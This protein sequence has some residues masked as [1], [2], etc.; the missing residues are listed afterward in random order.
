MLFVSL[1]DRRTQW[2][3]LQAGKYLFGA[4]VLRAVARFLFRTAW[5]M[6]P[7]ALA[8]EV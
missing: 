2:Q 7:L 4:K 1:P 5:I 6:E 8:A 3:L